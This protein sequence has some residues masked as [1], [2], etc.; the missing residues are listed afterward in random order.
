MPLKAPQ[1]HAM[2]VSLTSKAADGFILHPTVIQ[3]L[4][5]NCSSSNRH[6]SVPMGVVCSCLPT[7]PTRAE[8]VV[9]SAADSQLDLTAPGVRHISHHAA[10]M[11]GLHYSSA[12][13][14]VEPPSFGG[15]ASD[16]IY[17]VMWQA[18]ES[19][20]G[21]QVPPAQPLPSLRA[22]S[23]ARRHQPVGPLVMC[24]AASVAAADT[25]QLL[26]GHRSST[27]KDICVCTLGSV[28]IDQGFI[29]SQQAIRA[30]AISA[31]LKN[32][33]YELPSHSSQLFDVDPTDRN[34]VL[35][36]T[37][38]LGTLRPSTLPESDMY[39]V[40]ARYGALYRPLLTYTAS[41]NN[42]NVVPNETEAAS[43]V[44]KHRSYVIT[45]GLGGLG[46]LTALWFAHSGVRI[47]VLLSRSGLSANADAAAITG[48][49]ALITTAK[50]DV[51]FSEDAHLLVAIACA[52]NWQLGGIAHTAGLQ[53][54]SR[55]VLC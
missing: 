1:M 10:S 34:S 37:L 2:L 16:C 33:P 23:A 49:L 19:L 55:L 31:V 14:P 26:H 15:A 38:S 52:Q 42:S 50:C 28:P 41:G 45:G 46:M 40:A 47:V 17:V 36:G 25:V 12:A 3:A 44:S 48:S 54:G 53:V 9:Y 6:S 39:G 22:S 13:L 43:A 32:L 51:S 7:V 5:I 30:A 27:L 35:S 20:A 4:V 21:I 8:A 18:A 24:Q 11:E 29:A